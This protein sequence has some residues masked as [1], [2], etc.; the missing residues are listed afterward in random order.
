[1]RER[2]YGRIVMTSSSSGIY[3]NFGQTNYGAAKMSLIGFMNSLFLEGQKYGIHV[4]SLAPIAAT[5]MTENLL[6]ENVLAQLDPAA[7]TPAVI[8]MASEGAPTK[9]IIAAGAG[10]FARV[11]IQETP[12]VYLP[13]TERDAEHI[14]A[15]WEQIAATAGAVELNA[16]SDQTVKFLSRA[17]KA[18]G[19][20]IS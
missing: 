4:N 5:R 18:L 14:A 7:V 1:M 13:E 12:G 15:Q 8:F 3:G 9:Q 2:Q 11:A 20:E 16:G 10:V 19:I 6:P 17:A